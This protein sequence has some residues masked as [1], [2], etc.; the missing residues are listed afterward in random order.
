MPSLGHYSRMSWRGQR[1]A[2]DV[3]R[4]V[5]NRAHEERGEG[6]DSSSS[7]L[8][9]EKRRLREHESSNMSEDQLSLVF[10]VHQGQDEKY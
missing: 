6:L 8:S 9:V 5:E 7:F 10:H 4:G 2:V 3:P 1:G